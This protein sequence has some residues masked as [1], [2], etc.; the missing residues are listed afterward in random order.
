MTRI[1]CLDLDINEVKRDPDI[2]TGRI[3][4]KERDKENRRAIKRSK[5]NRH[6][7]RRKDDR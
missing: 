3:D 2:A 7:K 1:Y 6:S 4:Q 5:K